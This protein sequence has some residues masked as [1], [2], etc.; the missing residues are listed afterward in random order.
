MDNK[1]KGV[2]MEFNFDPKTGAMNACCNIEEAVLIMTDEAYEHTLKQIDESISQTGR[3][4]TFFAKEVF[5][6]VK[7][8]ITELKADEKERKAKIAEQMAK[9]AAKKPPVDDGSFFGK[10]K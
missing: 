1:I 7:T 3:M 8:L 5:P 9:E 10:K 6:F 4:G 2:K